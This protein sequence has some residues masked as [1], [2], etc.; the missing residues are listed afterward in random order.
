MGCPRR[1]ALTQQQEDVGSLPPCYIY[2][3]S[4]CAPTGTIQDS[5]PLEFSFLAEA[6]VC[7]FGVYPPLAALHGPH[8]PPGAPGDA[9]DIMAPAASRMECSFG[10]PCRDHFPYCFLLPQGS[11]AYSW[12]QTQ[13]VSIQSLYTCRA[14]VLSS[15]Q[16]DFSSVAS[17]SSLG[18]PGSPAAS[19]TF[20]LVVTKAEA[21]VSQGGG[22]GSLLLSRE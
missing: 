3:G 1:R 21:M 10:G 13:P 11:G 7:L 12:G 14:P 17:F 15:L 5:L 6:S 19:R 20:V 9:G 16:N 2:R 8:H 22:C 18:R 4:T